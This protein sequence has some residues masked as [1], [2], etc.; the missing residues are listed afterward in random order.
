MYT[1]ALHTA[2]RAVLAVTQTAVTA[3]EQLYRRAE[4]GLCLLQEALVFVKEQE[5]EGTVL[6]PVL[7][8]GTDPSIRRYCSFFWVLFSFFI[9]LIFCCVISVA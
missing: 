5:E 1:A 7:Q 6:V 8:E 4:K 3:V 2:G 9:L